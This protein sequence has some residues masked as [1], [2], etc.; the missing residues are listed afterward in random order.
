M[1]EQ[2]ILKRIQNI[3]SELFSLKRALI[4]RK[5][6]NIPKTLKGIWAG[7]EFTEEDFIEAKKAFYKKHDNLNG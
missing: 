5:K 2:E 6:T 1:S 4:L 7:I 3:E